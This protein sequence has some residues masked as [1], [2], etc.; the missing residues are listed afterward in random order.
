MHYKICQITSVHTRNDVRIF[1]KET[2]SLFKVGFDTT[3]LVADGLGNAE[4]NGINIIDA[5]KVTGGRLKRFYQNPKNILKALK[6]IDCDICHFHDPELI[7]VGLKLIRRGKKVI[8]DVHEDVPLQTLSKDYIPLI[9]R[10]IISMTIKLYENYAAKRLSYIVTATPSI[11]RRF[12]KL[13]SNTVDINNYPILNEINQHTEP[14]TKTGNAIYIGLISEGRGIFQ[15]LESLSYGNFKLKIAGIFNSETLKNKIE[16]HQNWNKVTFL[17]QLGRKE[18]AIE[19]SKAS[20]GIVT[21]LPEPNHLNSQP[22]K[23]FEYMSAGIP[24]IASN[25]PIWREIVEG[26]NCGVCIDPMKPTEIAKAMEY[27]LSNDSI[28]KEMGKN[29]RDAV[30]NKFNWESEKK[31]LITVYKQL[32]Q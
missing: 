29:G 7:P 11:K 30:V 12:I 23:M 32:C 14:H 25:F 15:L 13:N 24:I 21:L 5:G 27:L 16:N 8:Y 1:L 17:G 3:L 28:A 26:N 4:I 18:L 2:C 6:N 31:K 22:I 19:L 10:R 20:V 9:F